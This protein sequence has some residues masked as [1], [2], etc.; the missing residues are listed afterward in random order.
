MQLRHE[1]LTSH[2]QKNLAPLYLISGEVPLLIQEASDA[3]RK[4]AFQQ[5]YTNRHLL[6]VETG[7]SWQNFLNDANTSSLFADQ[8]L[9]ELRFT[10]KQLGTTGGKILQSYATRPPAQKILLLITNK[11]DAT[12]QKSAWFQAIGK[13]GVII[14]IWPIP[15]EQLPQWIKQR[16]SAVGLQAE[17]EGIQLLAERAEGNLLAAAQE[18]EKL[19]L[20]YGNGSLTTQ[21]II[22]AT[23]DSAR[24]DVFQLSDVILEG[25]KKR[26]YR[27]L[28]SLQAEGTEPI[29]VLWALARDLRTLLKI[30][31]TVEQGISLEQALQKHQVWE[32]RKALFRRAL[33]RHSAKTLRLLLQQASTVD[34]VIKGLKLGNMWD[35][36]ECL[37]YG[38][39]TSGIASHPYLGF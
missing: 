38:I 19:R 2:L 21:N 11:L 16:L 13:I 18:I 5:G 36:L 24:F 6:Q 12:Q 3:I 27:I 15:N 26:V 20:V 25:E 35:E 17:R 28:R 4:T 34:E 23:T 39:S 22:Q 29:L 7:F 14:Q 10:L 33:Q 31:H 9:L 8:Q 30:A 32:K 37:A 1:Q